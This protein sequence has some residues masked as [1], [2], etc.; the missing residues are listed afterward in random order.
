LGKPCGGG[1]NLVRIE[2]RGGKL[3]VGVCLLGE[4]T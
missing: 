1:K 2:K 3:K 4:K